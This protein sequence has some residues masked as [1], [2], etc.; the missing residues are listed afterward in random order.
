MT[1]AQ[2]DAI[3]SPANGL[4]IYNTSTGKHQ[5]Y[6]GSWK[7]FGGG[8]GGVVY[9][10]DTTTQ[11]LLND[12]D[13]WDINGVYIGTAITGTSQGDNHYNSNYKFEAVADNL[14]IRLIRG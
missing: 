1:T 3:S 4:I 12:V 9:I 8:G 6:D 14:W 7:D 11:N 5:G 13:N 2:R 10:T